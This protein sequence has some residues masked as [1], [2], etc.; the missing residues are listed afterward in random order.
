MDASEKTVRPFISK[1]AVARRLGLS[2]PALYRQI[3]LGLIPTDERGKIPR[4]DFEA[5]AAAL[6]ASYSGDA[7]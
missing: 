3:K 4:A 2:M 7:S 1:A 6:S 5:V